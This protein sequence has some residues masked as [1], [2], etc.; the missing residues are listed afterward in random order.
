MAD[1]LTPFE[2]LSAAGTI[3]STDGVVISRDGE[4]LLRGTVAGLFT[5]PALGGVP[6]APT[7]VPGT[8]TA[9]LATTAFVAARADVNNTYADAAA[10]DALADAQAYTDEQID[11]RSWKQAV[12]AATTTALPANSYSNGSSGVGATL[13]GTGNGALSA[14]DG[15]TLAANE[16]LLVK[17][18]SSAS[19]NGIYTL[20]Q[21]GDGSHPYI[22]TRRTDADTASKL[23]NATVKVSEGTASGDKSYT[24]TA[25][26]PIT[27]GTTA[28]P[29]ALTSTATTYSAD[30]T[31]IHLA[32]T[33]FSLK[34]GA[35]GIDIH[36]ASGKT[37]PVDADELGILDSAAG[38]AL[39]VLTWANLK[40]TLKTY[41]DTLYAK[42]G[43]IT[44][45]GLTMATGKLLGRSTASTGAVEEITVGSGL[46]LAAGTLSASGAVTSVNGASGVV[47]LNG[48]Y[49]GVKGADIASATT[50]DLATA[51]GDWVDV[52]GTATIT[53]LGTVAAGIERLVR[54][55]GI[56]TLTY[57]A[58][59]LILPTSAN[60]T[61]ANGDFA[62]FRSLGSGN[63]ACVGYQRRSGASLASSVAA[64]SDG[65]GSP[66]GHPNEIVRVN[67]AGTALEYIKTADQA[68]DPAHLWFGPSGV[69]IE[70]FTSAAGG[71][72]HPVWDGT[73]WVM[74]YWKSVTGSPYTRCYYR[75]APTLHGT[76]SSAT[77][78][79]GMANYHK[80]F[81]LV[82]EYGAPVQISSSYHAYAVYFNGALTDKEI[83][84]FTAT[85]LTGTWTLASKVIAKGASGAK[86]EYNTDTPFALYKNGTIYLWYMGAP[87]SSVADFATY[88]YAIRMLRATATNPDGAFTK[89]A[90]DVL[91]VN[92]SAAWDYG[93]MGGVQV[94]VRPG[95]GY[96]MVYNAG[97]TR[98]SSSGSEPNTSRA[99]FAYSDS[100]DGPWTKDTANPYFTPTGWPANG[101]E[102]TNIW[103]TCLAYDKSLGSWFAY[104]NSQSIGDGGERITYG[105]AGVY[106]Y[107]D[108]TG[109]APYDIL[110]M[111]TGVQTVT[112]SRVNLTP[113]VYRIRYAYN[114]G[115]I[116]TTKPALDVD[117][118]LRLDGTGAKPA[119]REFVGSYNYENRDVI[120]EYIIPVKASGYFDCSVQVT[121]G[122]PTA[123]SKIRRGRVTCERIRAA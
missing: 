74:F 7:A 26:A 46:T 1:D 12:R 122:T 118:V 114:V 98:P 66:S 59:S 123:V 96:M 55:T 36:A 18:E 85:T 61:T 121:G 73:Q 15:V 65:P 16:D 69:T 80:P 63:W 49:L 32:G 35:V 83:F 117:V 43:A 19:H 20:T 28:L 11:G 30:E 92:G 94:L 54:F 88:S 21:V 41:L 2:D 110:T 107:F 71:D 48:G 120:L 50:T 29:F 86:D 105:I 91:I 56:L 9:Q 51:T 87:T 104:Y 38:Y 58:T 101:V 34:A 77:E 42:I 31:T 119:S 45:S 22:L 79:T 64:I 40:A 17:D 23:L 27:V 53:A 75:T 60:I 25:D 95:G 6:T 116:G 33:T 115:D 4:T 103:R 84:H 68:P 10:A 3:L 52:T 57:N 39:K 113:G 8:S 14:Q 5:S 13:T 70:T 44:G 102:K 100:L 82:D 72:V 81:I 37:T 108:Q 97:D 67:S 99:G 111:T 78:I 90:S 62:R 106:D 109:G 47:S 76:W 24:G 93:W 89:S 112:N